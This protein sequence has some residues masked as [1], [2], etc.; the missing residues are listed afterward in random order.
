M[1]FSSVIKEELI[2]MQLKKNCCKKSFLL[3]LLINSHKTQGNMFEVEF[4]F[5]PV[6][7][8]VIDL[9]KNLYSVNPNIEI[10]NKP[11]KKYHRITFSLNSI[12]KMYDLLITD[13]ESIIPDVACFKCSICEQSFLRGA[14]LSCATITDPQKNYQLE[15]SFLSGNITIASKFYRFLSVLGFVPK[16]TNR[17]NSIGLYFK[18]NGMI[19]DI[20]YFLG[21]VGPSFEYAN[22]GIEKE[23]RNNENRATNCVTKNI[24]KSVS[25]SK[26]Q[27][28]A[29]EK[30][31]A[32]H[33]FDALPEELK[34]T[35]LIRLEN[36][37]ASLM[38]L[39]LMHNPPISKSGLN[40]RLK[41]ICEEADLI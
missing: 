39:A 36:E 15:F 24:Y 7:D 14:F 32:T 40:H 28:D 33:K 21:A 4:L 8:K 11:G 9:L 6:A 3:G 30:L 29:I 19:S 27:I 31:I 34:Q 22:A 2:E 23:I 37:E 10:V 41:K 35:A 38:E 20:L 25:A 17:K 12:S 26:K 13:P 1:S 16:I 18:S 5:K